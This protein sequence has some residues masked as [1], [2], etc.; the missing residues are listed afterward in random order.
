MP[1][2]NH[3]AGWES[4]FAI[5][6]ELVAI[7][8]EA[9][10]YKTFPVIGIPQMNINPN[11]LDTG[12]TARGRSER[13]E[14]EYATANIDSGVTFAARMGNVF[15][16]KMLATLLQLKPA[17]VET[18]ALSGKFKHTFV[19]YTAQPA[20][21][22][23]FSAQ[24][25]LRAGA[26]NE[27]KKTLGNIAKSIHLVTQE[28]DFGKMDVETMAVSGDKGTL[29][30]PASAWSNALQHM[31]RHL[32]VAKIEGASITPAPV[33]VDLTLTNGLIPWNGK[34]QTPE[35]LV[36]GIFGLTGN[37]VVTAR[38]IGM[39]MFDDFK[40]K[41]NRTLEFGWGTAV[42][43]VGYVRMIF[44]AIY[45]NH[46]QVDRGGI[47]G[48]QVDFAKATAA[49]APQATTIDIWHSADLAA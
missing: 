13:H 48:V 14:D 2:N 6:D 40:A 42:D 26:T 31:H 33:V 30:S 12:V 11:F 25:A 45:S 17:G 7:G 23:A 35:D 5:G 18:P 39:P 1:S 49:T 24:H 43:D 28:N 34:S 41:T 29:A 22:I 19:A 20:V 36:L 37:M 16:Y 15:L 3:Y 27:S 21:N 10:T 32:L 44:D 46:Q 4:H 38:A 8:T 9:V 47:Q